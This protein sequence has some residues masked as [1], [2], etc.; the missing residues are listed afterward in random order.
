MKV[1][2]YLEDL[3]YYYTKSSGFYTNEHTPCMTIFD[4]LEYLDA[5][6]NITPKV[7]TYFVHSTLMYLILTAL[8]IIRDIEPITADNYERMN[9][10][11]FK[12]S[13]IVPFSSNFAAVKYNCNIIDTNAN[14]TK[15][16][17]LLNQKPIQTMKWCKNGFCDWTMVKEKLRRFT[18]SVCNRTFCLP[19]KSV[20][21]NLSTIHYL[22]LYQIVFVII[23]HCNFV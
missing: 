10:R 13:E 7:S 9:N 14:V 1:F 6:D 15:I 3:G 16:L 23:L 17:F 22:Y 4:M 12:S 21:T 20:A 19:E 5:N 11:L 18:P 8:G 2:D